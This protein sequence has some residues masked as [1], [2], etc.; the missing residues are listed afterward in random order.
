M[1]K[2][3][4][5]QHPNAGLQKEYER[6]LLATLDEMQR[7]VEYWLLSAYRQN[8]QRIVQDAEP[9]SQVPAT[10]MQ[11]ALRRLQRYWLRRWRDR[12]DIL[13]RWFLRR[14]RTTSAAQ[15]KAA[16][17]AAGFTVKMASSRVMN[18]VVKALIAEN[19]SL[20]R[21]IPSQYFQQVESLVQRSIIQGR[22]VAYLRDELHHRYAVTQNRAKLIARD[23]NN[24]AFQAIKRVE[25]KQLGITE[26]IWVHVPGTKSSRKTHMKMN[27]KRFKLDEGLYD[28]DV[29]RK[30]LAGELPC[31]NC[32]YRA[33]I[34]EF[35]DK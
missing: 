3:L 33:V 30:V 22:D 8:K 10:W 20:I 21:S 7:S 15:F 34:P 17:K 35:G 26:G 28:A 25:N 19:V 27:G 5:A 1:A 9:P 6:K 18:D 16:M 12:A 11:W 32:T 23:Q 14:M 13:A 31:C 2:L 24:K 29:G 4:R